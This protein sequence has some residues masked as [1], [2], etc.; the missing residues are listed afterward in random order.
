[1]LR[2][3]SIIDYTKDGGWKIENDLSWTGI[4]MKPG[5]KKVKLSHCSMGSVAK[6]DFEEKISFLFSNFLSWFCRSFFSAALSCFIIWHLPLQ[7]ITGLALFSQFR[8]NEEMLI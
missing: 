6:K 4:E 3:T 8:A 5:L 7:C 1:M 2:E